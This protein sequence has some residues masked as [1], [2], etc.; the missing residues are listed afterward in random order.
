LHSC[1]GKG[2]A[3]LSLRTA[4]SAIVQ[5]FDVEIVSEE[6]A[7][8]FGEGWEDTYVISLPPLPLRFTPRAK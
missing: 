5:N 6:A 1:A 4:I 7:R 2:L 8:K 3:Y